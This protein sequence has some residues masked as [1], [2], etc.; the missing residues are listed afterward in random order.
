MSKTIGYFNPH[1]YPVC[2]SLSAYGVNVTLQK[3]KYVTFADG[4]KV[5]DPALDAFV[6]P[7]M[8][9]RETSKVEVPNLFLARVKS[10]EVSTSLGFGSSSSVIK[11][12]RGFVQDS[13]F[14]QISQTA[15]TDSSF[16]AIK[17]YSM[18]EAVKR[19]IIKPVIIPNERAPDDKAGAPGRG[20][21]IP[22]IAIARDANPGEARELIKS[23]MARIEKDV[24]APVLPAK[25]VTESETAED[26]A[27]EIA[28]LDIGAQLKKLAASLASGEPESAPA[29][30][31][32]AVEE[33]RQFKNEAPNEFICVADGKSFKKKSYLLTYAK[34]HFPADVDDIM[35]PYAEFT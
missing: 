30:E 20:D 2:I 29:L 24:A 14:K 22:P 31:Q 7:A 25:S 3:G 9:A 15:P 12:D 19:K 11:D 10:P 18:E 8:L 28:S 32:P 6:G 5:N 23:G 26:A 16:P 33:A 17:T 21:K 13:S 4:R 27:P 34:K 1:D 35:A